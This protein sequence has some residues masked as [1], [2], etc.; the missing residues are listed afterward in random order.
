MIYGNTEGIKN[1][2]LNKLEELYDA[3]ASKDEI[4]SGDTLELIS[5]VTSIVNR[6]ISIAIDRKGKVIY[7]A[8][9]DSASVEI[10]LMDIKEKKLSGI[11]I[12]HTHPSGSSRLSAVDTSALMKLK[13]DLIVAIGIKGGRAE[14]ATIGFC[15]VYNNTLGYESL[16]PMKIGD[17]LNYDFLKKI[18]YI[19]EV[20]KLEEV[21]EDDKDRAILISMENEESILELKELARACDVKVL[22]CILQKKKEKNAATYIGSGKVSEMALLCQAEKASVI[23][24][25]NELTGSQVRNLEEAIG[26]KVIDR[27]TL[28]LEIFARRARSKEAKIQV[29]LAQLKYRNAH[30]LGLGLIMS[31]TGGGIGTRGPGEK[32]LEIDKRHIKERIYDLTDELKNIKKVREV[33]REKRESIPKVSI[34]GY[35][36]AGKS[37]LR[38]KICDIAMPKELTV[39][40]KVFEANMLFATLDVTTRA[41]TLKDNRIIA[42][43]DT[44]GF[45]RKL[46]HELIESFKST[47]EEV[48]Y[49]DMLIH[50]VDI[51]SQNLEEQIDSVNKVLEELEAIDKITLLVFNKIDL[52][53]EE[54]IN[55]IK[56]KYKDYNTMF[57]SAKGSINIE[58]LLDEISKM[59]PSKLKKISYLIPYDDTKM[60]SFLHRNGKIIKE[61]YKEKGTFLEAEVD[62]EVYNKSL[63]YVLK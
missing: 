32:K 18:S 26:I 1:S 35:T 57:I 49:S 6:E 2:I 20:F 24:F 52:A 39:K 53:C 5:S 61:E 46:P 56:E 21:T 3:D 15:S 59:L 54:V 23:I 12:I 44:V 8:V 11:R 48:K 62:E 34:V 25:D 38:N 22:K 31:R 28:I 4:I 19:E 33:Q 14:E 17:F 50:V 60:V 40:D 30:I 55:E 13:L 58:E 43:S 37:T 41:V 27:N 36:N 47:L 29:E 16:G 42:L 63:K 51:C 7:I 45:I 10:P 9:G